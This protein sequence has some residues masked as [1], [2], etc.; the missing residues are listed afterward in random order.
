MNENLDCREARAVI[1]AIERN[2][3]TGRVWVI[4]RRV[5]VG[6]GSNPDFYEIMAEYRPMT[7]GETLITLMELEIKYLGVKFRAHR[8]QAR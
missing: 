4:Q 1:K 7:Q 8:L 6:T 5:R 3:L 2:V